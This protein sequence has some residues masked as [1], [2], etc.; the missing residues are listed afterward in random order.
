MIIWEAL[1]IDERKDYKSFSIIKQQ[2]YD[3][4][5]FK[6]KKQKKMSQLVK[7]NN[8]LNFFFLFFSKYLWFVLLCLF[9]IL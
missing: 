8:S 7:R 2:T 3:I 4:F 5:K 1:N 6:K 9:S